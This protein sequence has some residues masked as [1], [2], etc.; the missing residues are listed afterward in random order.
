[1]SKK[2]YQKPQ[3]INFENEINAG[4]PGALKGAAYM[5]GRALAKA[6]KGGIELTA[7]TNG[8]RILQEKQTTDS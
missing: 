5:V 1:M 4:V 2:K 3:A 8:P 6:M 7:G